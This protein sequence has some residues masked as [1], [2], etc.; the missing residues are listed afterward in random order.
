MLP[1]FISAIKLPSILRIIFVKKDSKGVTYYFSDDDGIM[2]VDID[3]E[4]GVKSVVFQER[5]CASK[6]KDC[7]SR[8]LLR[9]V[10]KQFPNVERLIISGECI[11]TIDISNMMF[12]NVKEVIV[13]DNDS[14]EPGP[15]LM[16]VKDTN[17]G[18]KFCLLNTFC[19]D[20]GKRQKGYGD[21]QENSGGI[22]RKYRKL[23]RRC[24]C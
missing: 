9:N 19:S 11:Y 13:K 16:T 3:V 18:R 14:Y 17:D 15:Y 6:W 20:A 7:Y 8:F 2:C 21:Y 23:R 22:F 12:P 24:V 5:Q 1:G 10:K 4:P